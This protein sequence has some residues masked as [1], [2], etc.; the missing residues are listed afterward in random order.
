MSFLKNKKFLITGLLN[1]KSIAYGIAK[2]MYMQKAS[3]AFTYMNY[4]HKNRIE[5]LAHHFNSDIVIKC[6]FMYEKEIK[7][8]FSHLY[9]YWNNFDGFIHSVAYADK[10][11]FS[12]NYTQTVNKKKFIEANNITTYSFISMLKKCYKKLNPGSSIVT[13]TYLGSNIA[14]PYYNIMGI[15]KSSLESTVRY[16]ANEFGRKNIR[17]NLISA[18]PIK[19]VSAYKIPNFKKILSYYKKFSPIKRLVTISEI[20]NTAAFLCSNLSSGITGQTIYVDGGL[21]IATMNHLY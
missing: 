6:N 11:Q 17:I 9:K 18:G 19:T 21:N 15:A 10:N 16:V 20:G 14:I 13:L 4:K 3:L 2:S 1:K 5:N 12:L 7:Y 8:L